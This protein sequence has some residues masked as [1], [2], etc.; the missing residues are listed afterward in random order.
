VRVHYDLVGFE[1]LLDQ[2]VESLDGAKAEYPIPTRIVAPPM[3][4]RILPALVVVAPFVAFAV[5]GVREGVLG[6]AVAFSLMSVGGL[7]LWLLGQAAMP[8]TLMLNEDGF[9][10]DAPVGGRY[11]VPWETMGV[12]AIAFLT[13]GRTE[14]VLIVTSPDGSTRM[15]RAG[16]I[17][18]IRLYVTLRRRCGRDG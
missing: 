3:A 9:G 18:P 8:S 10:M 2:A 15:I 4:R 12:P 11:F 5:I 6:M 1:E 16:W 13:R 14:P 7:A 17:D